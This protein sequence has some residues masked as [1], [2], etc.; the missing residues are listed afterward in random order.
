MNTTLFL[1]LALLGITGLAIFL[2][3]PRRF[4]GPLTEHER[5]TAHRGRACRSFALVLATPLAT[6][7]GLLLL[8]PPLVALDVRS[9]AARTSSPPPDEPI[10]DRSPLVHVSWHASIHDWTT[11][12]L[13]GVGPG[14]SGD[15]V[16]L[17]QAVVDAVHTGF[18]IPDRCVAA[19]LAERFT[20]RDFQN[21]EL[22]LV[23]L[24]ARAYYLTDVEIHAGQRLQDPDPWDVMVGLLT[25]RGLKPRLSSGGTVPTPHRI[26][27]L[28]RARVHDDHLE[29]LALVRGDPCLPY[30]A[31]LVTTT[32]RL[33]ITCTL[34]AQQ[35]PEGSHKGQRAVTMR[36][37]CPD[38]SPPLDRTNGARL[39][40]DDG[41]TAIVADKLPVIAPPELSRALAAAERT[42]GSFAEEMLRHGLSPLVPADSAPVEVALSDETIVVTHRSPAVPTFDDC[43]PLLEYGPFSWSG[44]GKHG[45]FVHSLS[46]LEIPIHPDLLRMNSSEYEPTALLATLYTITWAANVLQTGLCHE[47]VEL[48]DPPAP[49]PAHPLLTSTQMDEAIAGLRRSQEAF[50]LVS[51][52]L[53]ILALALGLRRSVL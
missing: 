29:V 3:L 10:A 15:D 30:P 4:S 49:I 27:R 8:V 35:C 20:A 7:V 19:D 6:I 17:A 50:G 24:A 38:L 2:Y 39:T 46:R 31:A 34:K 13:C 23:E 51:I 37:T 36:V 9:H 44:V 41:D 22:T 5:R 16:V 47:R 18:H 45:P 12:V 28:T 53:A 21:V 52:A 11:A 42:T 48:R 14:A 43:Q 32:D 26:L 1:W 40:A 33:P 25:A